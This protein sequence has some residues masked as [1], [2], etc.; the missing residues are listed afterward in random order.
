MQA[1]LNEHTTM[2]FRLIF[3]PME[4]TPLT[5]TFHLGG[6]S[7]SQTE[8]QQ[9]QLTDDWQ[10]QENSEHRDAEEDIRLHELMENVKRYIRN[11]DV[12]NL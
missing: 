11:I 1:I 12:N 7:A 3:N 8:S 5:H 6:Q 4:S 10:K 2:I 9:P